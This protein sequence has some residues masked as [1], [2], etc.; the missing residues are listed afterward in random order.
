MKSLIRIVTK[1]QSYDGVAVGLITAWI[2]YQVQSIISINQIG[3]AVWG[4]LLSGL[5]IGYERS[6]LIIEANDSASKTGTKT[7]RLHQ[8]TVSPGSMLAV[9]S[10]GMVGFL[11]ALPPVTADIK[12]RS[13]QTSQD[14]LKLEQS[15]E[16]NYFNPQNSQKYMQNIQAFEASGLFDISHKY[17]IKAV[18]WNPESYELWRILYLVKNST[19]AEREM[20]ISK[21]KYLDPLNPDVTATQ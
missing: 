13:A 6:L 17:A 16:T 5:L 7:K 1:L 3:L 9:C 19:S 4:W 20:A 21:M 10:L 2:C 18:E 15:M 12:W 11:L 14:A 8:T